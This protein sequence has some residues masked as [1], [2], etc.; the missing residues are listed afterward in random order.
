[1]S[2]TALTK[3]TALAYGV[4][5]VDMSFQAVD[6]GNDNSFVNTPKTRLFVTRT[7]GAV[8]VTAKA[9]GP[10]KYTLNAAATK[11]L[12]TV[13]DGKIGTFA[14]DPAIY[15]TTVTVGFDTG[16]NV[17]AAVVDYEDTPL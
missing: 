8:V 10:N 9:I 3:V 7:G 13:A 16:A 11:A 6:Q 12:G 4:G 1:M 15:G 17:K 5:V 14:F 2:A